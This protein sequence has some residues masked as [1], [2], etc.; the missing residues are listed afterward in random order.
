M[1]NKIPDNLDNP[2]DNILYKIIDTQLE[3]YNDL[4]LTP[5]LLTTISLISGLSSVYLLKNDQFVISA[6]LWFISYYFDCTDGKMARKFNMTSRFGD[7]YD[8]ASDT[9]KHILLF[10]VLYSK[11]KDNANYNKILI[12]FI[13]IFVLS[14][15][16][17]GCQEKLTKKLTNKDESPTL[18][19][20]EKLVII[21]CEEQMKFTR[22]FGPAT[23]TIYLIL[24]ILYIKLK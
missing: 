4:H 2:I 11:L 15:A 8:H 21:D 9:L 23:I 10:Y 19:I 5:N 1:V 22:Y 24:V 18:E 12:I 3:F 16:Q 13:V 6:I 14:M 7:L 20:T 17:L